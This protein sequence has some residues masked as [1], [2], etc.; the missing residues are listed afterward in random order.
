MSRVH[1][2]MIQR[3]EHYTGQL[4]AK[5][6]ETILRLHKGKI[7][8]GAYRGT[9]TGSLKHLFSGRAL[10]A[11]GRTARYKYLKD[12]TEAESKALA[13]SLCKDI[14][15]R[16][17]VTYKAEQIISPKD[18]KVL[19]DASEAE[20]AA[21][22]KIV[23]EFVATTTTESLLHDPQKAAE[24]RL[25]QHLMDRSIA[26]HAQMQFL[27]K[28]VVARLKQKSSRK[29]SH[30]PINSKTKEPEARLRRF[31]QIRRIAEQTIDARMPTLALLQEAEQYAFREKN[32]GIQGPDRKIRKDGRMEPLKITQNPIP[33]NSQQE[34]LAAL[35]K[36]TPGMPR[37]F[38]AELAIEHML[39]LGVTVDPADFPQRDTDKKE[40]AFQKRLESLRTSRSSWDYLVADLLED[41]EYEKA[42]L[43][44]DIAKD[45]RPLLALEQL[46]D[47][48]ADKAFS[49]DQK[50]RI[51]GLKKRKVV[52]RKAPSI[53]KKRP[54]NA[55]DRVMPW[56]GGH[57]HIE[58]RLAKEAVSFPLSVDGNT[59]GKEEIIQQTINLLKAKYPELGSVHTRGD[60]EVVRQYLDHHVH[61]RTVA[62]V[63]PFTYIKQPLKDLDQPLVYIEEDESPEQIPV[64]TSISSENLDTPLFE[65]DKV[66]G[67][68]IPETDSDSSS[69]RTTSTD[70]GRN[71]QES[72]RE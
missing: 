36:S 68:A 26:H 66:T 46:R 23:D 20:R 45:A 52:N 29:K 42:I 31:K 72:D 71:F 37:T 1:Q 34:I 53:K 60:L 30:R 12:I 48:I 10:T 5:D 13:D 69:L 49:K 65:S 43:L 16:T 6:D 24:T 19:L 2:G 14:S 22:D 7:K 11:A 21:F 4:K 47:K 59:Q 35:E 54:Q 44:E 58:T 64:T 32:H 50:S 15:R 39:E 3:L 18:V 28:Q 57:T 56:R 41:G 40:A 9:I 70:S 27:K 55:I 63:T 51:K 17:P 38:I 67:L 25:G 8:K 61:D 62:E 33:E